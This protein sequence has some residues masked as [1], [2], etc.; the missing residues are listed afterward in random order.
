FGPSIFGYKNPEEID[1]YEY[2]PEKARQLLAEA[3]YPDGIILK[4]EGPRGRYM[5]DAELTEAIAGMLA[6]VGVKTEITISEWGTF[7]PKTVNGE[8]EH[9]WL[10]GLG[11]TTLDAEYYYNLYLTSAGRGYYHK[12][13]IDE[14]IRMRSQARDLQVRRAALLQLHKT[15][16]EEEPLCIFLW[17]QAEL[18]AHRAA[19][20]SWPPRGDECL[21]LRFGPPHHGI[22][23]QAAVP[24]VGLVPT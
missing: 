10:L 11:N 19:I 18:N 20:V 1:D 12:P 14:L 9:L 24:G 6:E 2:D 5:A 7:W 21:A 16:V 4:F 8:Q 13:E 23:Q 22:Q 15:L 3:G 17:A